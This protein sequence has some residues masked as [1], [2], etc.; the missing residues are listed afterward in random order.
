MQHSQQTDRH[1]I[2]VFEPAIP[3]NE[4]PQTHALDS[5][6]TGIGALKLYHS[7]LVMKRMKYFVL[8]DLP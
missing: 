7:G 4:L 2:A 6:V 8:Q 1:A 5:A 3:A